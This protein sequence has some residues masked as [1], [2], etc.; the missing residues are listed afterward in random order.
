MKFPPARVVGSS[1]KT[2]F[3]MRDVKLVLARLQEVN[4]IDDKEG[5][6]VGIN[7]H[8]GRRSI[9]AFGKLRWRRQMLE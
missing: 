5:K 1:I 4:F 2:K 6:S 9:A 7:Y 8:I 3:E